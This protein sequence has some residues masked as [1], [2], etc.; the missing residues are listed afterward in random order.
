[1]Y[2]KLSENDRIYLF[3]NLKKKINSSWKSLYS[4]LDVSK[5]MFF[6]YLS[7]KYPL[8][9][10]LFIKLKKISGINL[11]NYE[12]INIEKFLEK[13]VRKPRISPAMAEIIGI[14]NGDGHV[15]KIN[16]PICVIG[17]LLEKDYFYYMRKLFENTLKLKFSLREE[18]DKLRL[19]AY[20]KNMVNILEEDYSIPIGKKLGKLR[21]HPSFF[22]SKTLLASYLRGVYDTDGTIYIRRKKEPVLEIASADPVFLKDLQKAFKKFDLNAG[23]SS[24]NLYL[25]KKEEIKKFFKIVKPANSKHLKR[26][27]MYLK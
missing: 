25:Y 5:A 14:L 13:K 21:I 16:Y 7:G 4:N 27:K 26:Y 17:N 6:N 23:I 8:P 18:K 10:K 1:M 20:S 22:K 15:N 2:I 11:E 9:E 12:K 3:N 24:Q 19:L